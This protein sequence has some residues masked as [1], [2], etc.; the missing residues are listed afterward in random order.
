MI[1]DKKLGDEI[2]KEELGD[3]KDIFTGKVRLLKIT[4]TIQDE[5]GVTMNVKLMHKDYEA[6]DEE[7]VYKKLEVKNGSD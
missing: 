7:E 6:E 4:Y 3:M 5:D 1:K 2:S